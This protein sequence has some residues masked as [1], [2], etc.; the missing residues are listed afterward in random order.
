MFQTI[1]KYTALCGSTLLIAMAAATAQAADGQVEFTGVINDNA[2]TINSESV[3][4]SV[5]MGQV[6]IADFANT[7]GATAGETPFS[8]S[9]ENCSGSTLKNASIKFSGQ[10]AAT[11]ATVL[12]MVG[13]NQVKG[14]G[15]QIA[16]ARTGD[17]LPLN[18][19][20]TD[21]VLRP[22]SNT[23]DFTASYVRLVADTPGADGAP[24][25]RGIGTGTVNALAT[26]DV[27]YK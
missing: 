26:F 12:G 24:D 8:I 5:D 7:V 6:R 3:K 21:Y 20:S 17:K 18:T 2:C 22:Q 25:T 15:I 4:K 27:T 1:G 19:A 9:L 13:A 16:D 11:D 23:F 14:L 10:Q